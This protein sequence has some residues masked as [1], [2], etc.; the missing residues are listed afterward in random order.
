VRSEANVSQLRSTNGLCTLCNRNQELKISQLASYVPE[1][2]DNYDYEIE[3]YTKKLDQCYKLC[4]SCE[5]AVKRSLINVKRNILANLAQKNLNKTR[6]DD[7]NEEH[8]RAMAEKRK[9]WLLRGALYSLLALAL[10]NLYVCASR[11]DISR[12]ELEKIF[13]L[14]LANGIVMTVAHLTAVKALLVRYL[15]DNSVT[16]LCR[17]GLDNIQLAFLWI[18][19]SIGVY[20]LL[21]SMKSAFSDLDMI[22][23]SALALNLFVISISGPANRERVLYSILTWTATMA[24]ASVA[25][26]ETYSQIIGL[27]TLVLMKVRTI[28]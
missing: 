5:R 21:M 14:A 15:L 24:L 23:V 17:M 4:S 22:G 28:I 8:L 27:W 20:Q 18:S 1:F 10:V 13:P 16:A 11:A 26:V 19:D 7:F 9:Q 6:I 3:E 2:E 25:V 12:A